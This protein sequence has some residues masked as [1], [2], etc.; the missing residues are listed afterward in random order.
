MVDQIITRDG[1]PAVS[2]RACARQ[3][4]VSPSA[5]FRHFADKRALLTAYAVSGFDQMLAIIAQRQANAP[6]DNPMRRFRAVG[7]GYFDFAIRHPG[8]FQVMFGAVALDR[9]DPDLQAAEARLSACLSGGLDGALGVSEP[10][11]IRAQKGLLAWAVVHGL[12]C[13]TV[14]RQL[15][16]I[17]PDDPHEQRRFLLST[18][19]MMAPA[20]Q[21]IAE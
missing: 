10:A 16:D 17:L 14:D 8:H 4:G 21:R 18:M 11:A 2:L 7:E 3:L 1:L 6:P 20:F 13:L 5:P 9:D 12:A 15:D 19:A